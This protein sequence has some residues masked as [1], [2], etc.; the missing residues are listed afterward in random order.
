L[1]S[2]NSIILIYL[3]ISITLLEP[4]KCDILLYLT[5]HMVD[6][7][8]K[9][10]LKQWNN[11]KFFKSKDLSLDSTQDDDIEKISSDKTFDTLSIHSQDINEHMI[12]GNLA[13]SLKSKLSKYND[14]KDIFDIESISNVSLEALFLEDQDQRKCSTPQQELKEEF[15]GVYKRLIIPQETKYIELILCCNNDP[16]TSFAQLGE[17]DD[18]MFPNVSIRECIFELIYVK[19]QSRIY[20][21]LSGISSVLSAI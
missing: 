14:D 5:N 7:N 11:A 15:L 21:R 1:H 17:N 18:I 19:H 20:I 2:R 16:I 4:W 10:E 8:I 9:I 13:E 3:Q 6:M 12:S